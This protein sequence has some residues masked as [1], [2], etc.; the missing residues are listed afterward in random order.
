MYSDDFLRCLVECDV[1]GIRK[2]W[3]HVAPHLSQPDDKDALVS[4]HHARTQ[5]QSIPFKLRAY[6]HRW[7][8]DQGYP[9]G[10]PDELKP[11]AERIYP[12]TQE[13]VGIA[14]LNKSPITHLTQA[15]MRDAVSEAYADKRTDPVFVKARMMEARETTIRKLV[16]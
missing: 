16:G 12:V 15:A 14:A 7:L 4:I 10:L 2:L 3:A 1:T 5:A 8:V 6:S 9:S 11:R 13:C